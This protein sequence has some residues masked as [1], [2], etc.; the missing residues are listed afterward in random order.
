MPPIITLT[1]DFG[2]SDGYVAAMKGVILDICPSATLVDISHDISPQDVMQ[3]AFV[4]G[5]T[6]RYFPPDTVNLAVVDPGV[7]SARHPMLL[8][9][10]RGQYV[11]PDNGLLTY[12]LLENYK[13]NVLLSQ[14]PTDARRNRSSYRM[15]YLHVAL[16]VSIV[17][18]YRDRCKK[19]LEGRQVLVREWSLW[20]R[21]EFFSFLIVED[22]DR[23]DE[24]SKEMG[25]VV[26][27]V[28]T[29]TQDMGGTMEYCHGVGVKLNHLLERELGVGHDV[30]RDLKQALDPAN[31]MNPGK[32]GL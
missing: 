12:V 26:D 14:N 2:L 24:T 23:R 28:L 7:G 10:P 5:T 1:T 19:I 25:N 31:I 32:L 11:A 13:Q 21:P 22:D 15:D 17:L 8:V 4:L 30:I 27:R 20:A 16:P 6:S 3:G 29:L 18:N 9:T